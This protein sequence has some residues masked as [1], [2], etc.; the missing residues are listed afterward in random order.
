MLYFHIV[1]DQILALIISFRDSLILCTDESF[2][3]MCI[4]SYHLELEHHWYD[5]WPN[6]NKL[7]TQ[8]EGKNNLGPN[9]TDPLHILQK[10]L[11]KNGHLGHT[12]C[13]QS[14]ANKALY[15]AFWSVEPTDFKNVI[16]GNIHWALSLQWQSC[17]LKVWGTHLL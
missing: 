6:H 8:N 10:N 13:E 5:F 2:K 17:L 12:C 14:Q 3:R 4:I 7:E 16:I 15:S 1:L 11:L 9:K